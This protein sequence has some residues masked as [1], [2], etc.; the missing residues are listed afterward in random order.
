MGSKIKAWFYGGLVSFILLASV[1][2]SIWSVPFR[3]V[4]SNFAENFSNPGYKQISP[5]FIRLPKVLE[6]WVLLEPK[7]V[8]NHIM[9]EYNDEKLILAFDTINEIRTLY[10]STLVGVLG[11]VE[12]RYDF[13]QAQLETSVLGR[14]NSSDAARFLSLDEAHQFIQEFLQRK[15]L[16]YPAGAIVFVIDRSKKAVYLAIHTA[17]SKDCRDI[18]RTEDTFNAWFR[19]AVPGFKPEPQKTM[20]DPNGR[21]MTSIRVG[22]DG[23]TTTETVYVTNAQLNAMKAKKDR[24]QTDHEPPPSFSIWSGKLRAAVGHFTKNISNPKCKQ[25]SPNFVQVPEELAK[26][27]RSSRNIF[28]RGT[29]LQDII[30][31][32]GQGVFILDVINR[33]QVL[34]FSESQT[35]PGLTEYGVQNVRRTLKEKV[36]A[37]SKE[38]RFLS[39]KEANRFVQ[40][41][42]QNSETLTRPS[43]AVVFV[44]DHS[45]QAVYLAVDTR[46]STKLE[47]IVRSV[48]TFDTWFREAVPSFQREPEVIVNPKTGWAEVQ[49]NPQGQWV[50]RTVKG[51]DGKMQTKTIYLTNSSPNSQKNKIHSKLNSTP[52]AAQAS[53]KESLL[54]ASTHSNKYNWDQA[55]AHL[56][57]AAKGVLVVAAIVGLAKLAQQIPGILYPAGKSE[58]SKF[59]TIHAKIVLALL[60]GFMREQ[61]IDLSLGALIQ[62]L[63]QDPDFRNLA[64]QMSG[65]IHFY[66]VQPELFSKAWWQDFQKNP[67]R[68]IGQLAIETKQNICCLVVTSRRF[69]RPNFFQMLYIIRQDSENQLPV[70]E[71]IKAHR[72]RDDSVMNALTD[73]CTLKELAQNKTLFLMVDQ[74]QKQAYLIGY[75]PQGEAQFLNIFTSK[76]WQRWRRVFLSVGRR[77]YEGIRQ[78]WEGSSA[79]E[80]LNFDDFNSKKFANQEIMWRGAEVPKPNESNL[81]SNIR[82]E[83]GKAEPLKRN[84]LSSPEL[85]IPN[86]YMDSN[87]YLDDFKTLSSVRR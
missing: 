25:I 53:D 12:R 34:H 69:T 63:D 19:E 56:G 55:R 6:K 43:G 11:R 27:I 67:Q 47:E 14:I 21:W 44:I 18:I 79:N 22:K 61:G 15:K 78:K 24:P 38:K 28:N 32:C 39:L 3:K 64:A 10:Y 33:T 59:I 66:N 48:D 71:T 73:K 81:Q 1:E 2:S 72:F 75:E 31:K 37:T 80:A 86:S 49:L 41:L 23:K 45:T 58:Q 16:S 7:F 5:N 4:V 65:G 84:D 26:R 82:L 60:R 36:F 54:P 51:P 52:V 74:A 40:E 35:G 76:E 57:T 70:V 68:A 50:T 62:E 87:V 9:R 13:M 46:R 77:F 20:S 17:K 83:L 42:V 29:I 85:T 8:V 30:K